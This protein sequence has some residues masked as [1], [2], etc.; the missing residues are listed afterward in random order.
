VQVLVALC[1]LGI[2][3]NDS[4][5]V[6]N[7][8]TLADNILSF[9]NADGSFRNTADD[10]ESNQMSTEQALYALAAVQRINNGKTSLYRMNTFPDIKNHANQTAIEVL[11]SLGIIKGR[12][13]AVFDPDAPITRAEFAA[14]ITRSLELYP[15]GAITRQEAAIIITRAAQMY[16]MDDAYESDVIITRAEIAEMLYQILLKTKLP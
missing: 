15:D 5:F 1:E 9:R 10:T 6:K 11:A 13:E 8:N 7:G 3:I 14:I 12:S 2:D 16:A 4:R